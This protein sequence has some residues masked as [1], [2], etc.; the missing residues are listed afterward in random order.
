[1]KNAAK[2]YGAGR[3]KISCDNVEKALRSKSKEELLDLVSELS[4]RYA[5]ARQ[6]ILERY[7][8]DSGDTRKLVNTHQ[9]I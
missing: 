1:M 8:L 3:D 5:D 7:L 9:T 6:F 2:R 4:G